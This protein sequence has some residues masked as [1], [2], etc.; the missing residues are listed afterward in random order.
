MY[1][2]PDDYQWNQYFTLLRD[3]KS[4]AIEADDDG[5]VYV[6]STAKNSST[7][8]RIL[9]KYGPDGTPID[10][11]DGSGTPWFVAY[12]TSYTDIPWHKIVERT[13]GARCRDK[14]VAPCRGNPRPG[15]RADLTTV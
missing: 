11:P 3:A 12:E 5:N 14:V 6:A 10:G 4:Y 2:I 1:Q 9:Q 13:Y 7:I 8:A 15:M